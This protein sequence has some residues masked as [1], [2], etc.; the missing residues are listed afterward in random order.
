ML[1]CEALPACLDQNLALQ[2]QES[3]VPG[4][5]G[6][7]GLVVVGFGGWWWWWGYGAEAI[8][9]GDRVTGGLSAIQRGQADSTMLSTPFDADTILCVS[10]QPCSPFHRSA[11]LHL[12]ASD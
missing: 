12:V 4:G 3:R 7:M 9:C 6:R 8:P 5:D 2:N 11:T 10:A 1:R